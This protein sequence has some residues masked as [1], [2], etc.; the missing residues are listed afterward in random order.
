M[1]TPRPGVLTPTQATELPPP[2][3]LVEHQTASGGT[4]RKAGWTAPSLTLAVSITAL[5]VAL[6]PVVGLFNH[7]PADSDPL[8]DVILAT[9]CADGNYL[10]GWNHSLEPQCR[11]HPATPSPPLSERTSETS[12][13]HPEETETQ[14]GA[15]P[16]C[17]SSGWAQ[18]DPLPCLPVLGSD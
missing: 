11:P 13:A 15:Y 3:A 12:V 17:P 16:T 9:R 4:A 14:P 5:S 8:L 1:P 2:T 10:E 7:G 18:T 6:I